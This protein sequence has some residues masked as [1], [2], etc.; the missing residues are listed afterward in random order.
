[1]ILVHSQFC[2]LKCLL[3]EFFSLT[4]IL[5]HDN[6][7]YKD[8]CIVLE[9]LKHTI[10]REGGLEW[11]IIILSFEHISVNNYHYTHYSKD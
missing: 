7:Y 9:G 6:N 1:M 5:V 10:A 8:F 11:L 4:Q 2:R 3:L